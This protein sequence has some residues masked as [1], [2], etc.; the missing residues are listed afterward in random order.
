MRRFAERGHRQGARQGL[1]ETAQT[2]DGHRPMEVLVQ[3][4]GGRYKVFYSRRADP[5]TVRSKNPE[6]KLGVCD[7]TR[8]DNALSV[9]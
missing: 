9:K 2:H 8:D 3:L 1:P 6:E 5:V 7:S 4:L